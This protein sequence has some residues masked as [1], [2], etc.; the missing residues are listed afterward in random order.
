MGVPECGS[1]GHR[2]ALSLGH[3]TCSGAEFLHVAYSTPLGV[4]RT[5]S[6][7]FCVCTLFSLLHYVLVVTLISMY[8]CKRLQFMKIPYE[9]DIIDKRKTVVLK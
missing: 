7:H 3:L 6:L 2:A 8:G 9:R 5:R 4:Q 1:V